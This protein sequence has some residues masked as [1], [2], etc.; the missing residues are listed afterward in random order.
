MADKASVLVVANRTAESEQLLEALKKRAGEGPAEFTLLV[1]AT[2]HGVSW[3]AD[4]YSGEGEAKTHLDRAVERYRAAGLDVVDARVGDPDPVAAVEDAVNFGNFDEIVVSTLPTHL[5]KWLK[6]DLP[7][8]V[9]RACGLPVT[10]V[11]ATEVKA[12]A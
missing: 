10:H 11:K 2:P 9:Q 8:R 7:R 1:P 12:G 6:L 4:M 3:A 5:S